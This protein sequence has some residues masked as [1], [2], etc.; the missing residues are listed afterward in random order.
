MSVCFRPI[1]FL[2]T[3]IVYRLHSP[4]EFQFLSFALKLNELE[5]E[6]EM[7]I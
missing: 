2:N 4:I 3:H 6:L 7:E 1:K 5:L